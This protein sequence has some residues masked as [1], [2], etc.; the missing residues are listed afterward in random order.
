MKKIIGLVVLLMGIAIILVSH[1]PSG[2]RSSVSPAPSGTAVLT[3]SG[4]IYDPARVTKKP[5]GLY[6]SPGNSPV[7][8]ER[9]AGFHTGTDFETTAAEADIDV[10][11]PAFCDGTLLVN[12]TASGYGGVAVQSCVLD[13]QTVTVIYGHLKQPSIVPIGT[14][15]KKGDRVG[16][17]GKGFSSETDGER[18]HL[19]LGAHKGTAINITG[20]ASSGELYNWLNPADYL[21]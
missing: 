4:P 8:P 21:N 15:L 16:I 11:V 2:P 18:K 20:Y 10:P 3:T 19:H 14:I 7:S 13:G 12:R 5:F 1:R 6:V 17:L 9:F